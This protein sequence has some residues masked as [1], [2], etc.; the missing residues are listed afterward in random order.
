MFVPT[1]L[2][3][4]L[5]AYSV[6]TSIFECFGLKSYAFG[7][8]RCGI[9]YY[10]GL[11]DTYENPRLLE[12]DVAKTLLLSFAKEQKNPCLLVPTTDWYVDL[13][14]RLA[15]Y[16]PPTFMVAA[17]QREQFYGLSRKEGFYSALDSFG[18]SHPQTELFTVGECITVKDFPVII[19]PSCSFDMIKRPFAGQK[20]IYIV[21]GPEELE[22]V[23]A[24]LLL[25]H[26]GMR[27]LIQPYLK[28]RRSFVLTVFSQKEFGVR[29]ASLAEVALEEIGD[30][31]R[32]NYCALLVRDLT[33]TAGRLIDFCNQIGYEG[34]ANFDIIETE[35]GEFVLDMN[36]RVGRSVD[37][38]RG[39]GFR[40]A[41][42]L[43]K[44]QN[45]SYPYPMK[46]SYVPVFWRSVSDKE[47]L[48]NCPERLKGEIRD[49]IRRG[50]AT[51]P[52]DT[53]M[54][55]IPLREKSYHL[56]HLLRAS[57]ATSLA[58]RK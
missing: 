29:C 44:S 20:K 19:K 28:A 25:Y 11:L 9:S 51:S 5:T 16:L 42:F 33:D 58:Y 12:T 13:A 48:R 57:R 49:R 27:Y 18:I 7:R 53:G 54:R 22:R 8:Y 37:Y 34:I 1:L 4:D 55:R 32:G 52:Y 3:V 41:D 15:P 56:I 30:S 2:G 23:L 24:L 17:P 26:K 47:I 31:A 35:M 43:L 38:L 40:V 50:F 21:E 46:F 36:M 14:L 45:R 6:A 39:A 10:S